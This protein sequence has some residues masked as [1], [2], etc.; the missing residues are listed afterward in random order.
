MM[1]LA[2][3]FDAGAVVILVGA[4]ILFVRAAFRL[5]DEVEPRD[6]VRAARTRPKPR[7]RG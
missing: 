7:W 4:L 5:I 3:A 6:D 2:G 1:L